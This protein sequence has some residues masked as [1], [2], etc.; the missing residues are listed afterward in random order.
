MSDL[1]GRGGSVGCGVSSPGEMGTMFHLM[2]VS[3]FI[4]QRRPTSM[5][6]NSEFR[7]VCFRLFTEWQ[8]QLS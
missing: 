5:C 7:E 8:D 3:C 1:N 4:G 6:S 2:G